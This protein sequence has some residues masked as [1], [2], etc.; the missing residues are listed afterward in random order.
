MCVLLHLFYVGLFN[1]ARGT[2]YK[3]IFKGKCPVNILPD[4]QKAHNWSHR[5]IPIVLVQMDQDLGGLTCVPG[6]PNVIP[7]TSKPITRNKYNRIQLPLLPAHC[8]TIHSA[9]GLTAEYGVVL[10]PSLK[11]PFAYGLEYVGCSRAKSMD[12]IQ[13][14]I[15]PL[16]ANHFCAYPTSL[17]NIKQEY[18]RLERT[19]NV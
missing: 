6:V 14:L 11:K 17:E 13:I 4:V 18:E 9:Q 12:K 8:S 7:I 5:E 2:V 15:T 3:F 19:V 10:K 16:R 1:G